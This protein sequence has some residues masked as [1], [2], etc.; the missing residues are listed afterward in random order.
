MPYLPSGR[1]N[2]KCLIINNVFYVIGGVGQ[3]NHIFYLEL[4]YGDSEWQILKGNLPIRGSMGVIQVDDK[5]LAFGGVDEENEM[6]R[7]VFLI[8]LQ[9]QTYTALK[10]DNCLQEP[11]RFIYNQIMLDSDSPYEFKIAGRVAVH[12]ITQQIK[13]KFLFDCTG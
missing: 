8:Q 10:L 9:S 5:I 13:D 6:Y 7:E 1:I 11:D 3:D 2:P 12:R 4:E